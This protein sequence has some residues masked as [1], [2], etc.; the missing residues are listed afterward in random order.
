[1]L[2][3]TRGSR[4]I[5]LQCKDDRTISLTD[6]LRKVHQEGAIDLAVLVGSAQ[7]LLPSSD[8]GRAKTV[9]EASYMLSQRHA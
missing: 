2:E 9:E 1:M 5:H 6:I 8:P 7:R 4:A 3:A